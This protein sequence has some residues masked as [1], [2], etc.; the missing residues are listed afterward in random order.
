MKDKQALVSHLTNVT[1]SN[2]SDF[3]RIEHPSAWCAARWRDN[4]EWVY[5]LDDAQCRELEAAV[6]HAERHALDPLEHGSDAFPLPTLGMRL[7]ALLGELEGGRGFVLLRGL[8][9]AGRDLGWV[10]TLNA[11]I[12]VHLGHVIRQNS[13]GDRVGHVTNRGDAYARTG[14]RGHGSND[15]IQPHCDS[16]DLVGL[17]CVQRAASG[18]ES[19]IAS[20]TA[21]YNALVERRRDLLPVLARGFRINLAGKGPSGDPHELSNHRIPVFSVYQ[22]LVSCRFN[23]KQIEDAADIAGEVLDAREREAIDWV[24]RLAMDDT[25]R[26]DMRFEPGDMQLLNNH[27]VLHARRAYCDDDT[28]GQRRLL[29]RTWIN[30]AHGRPLAPAFADRLNTG[31]RGEVA[32]LSSDG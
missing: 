31:P 28:R 26:F 18:G 12:S 15:A 23:R 7:R 6:H 9:I 16:A 8:P 4:A 1:G 27:C 2:D 22:G 19:C 3:A 25:F 13:R 5:S 21:I 17:L 10:T 29:L 30:M 32:A 20:S 24:S 14:V 11:G